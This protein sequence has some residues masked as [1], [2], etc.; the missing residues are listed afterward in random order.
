MDIAGEDRAVGAILDLDPVGGDVD[1]RIAVVTLERRHRLLLPHLCK[2]S[3][4]RQEG[5]C[6]DDANWGARASSDRPLRD[7]QASTAFEHD[8]VAGKIGP[9]VVG[10]ELSQAHCPLRRAL[11]REL[12]RL[13]VDRHVAGV[14][15]E[16]LGAGDL[17]GADDGDLLGVEI[18]A[19]PGRRR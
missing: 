10:A 14:E 7:F 6:K 16:S 3:G 8:G 13:Q 1:R 11:A 9:D 15:L 18:V 12:P 4:R 5:R 2:G 17:H 19:C